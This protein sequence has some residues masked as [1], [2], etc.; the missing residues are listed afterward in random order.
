MTNIAVLNTFKRIEKKYILSQ[1]TYQELRN[2]LTDTMLED[3]YGWDTICSLYYDSENFDLIRRSIDKPSYK[4]KLR[5][6]SYNV[7]KNDTKVYVELKKKYNKVVYKRRIALKYDDA[8]K[9]LE[10]HT[11]PSD[12]ST[13]DKQIAAELLYALD[14]YSLRP[15]MII[16]YDRVALFCKD[17]PSLRITFDTNIRSRNTDL[18]LSNGCYG[19]PVLESGKYIM[20]IKV[21]GSMPLWLVKIL[22]E[23]NIDPGSFSKYGTASKQLLGLVPIPSK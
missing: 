20:E 3:Q 13:K 14:F 11:L 16:A 22:R 10:N 23:L 21:N 17:E 9:F 5:L 19:S 12:L 2:K 1:D 8:I 6:R 18:D 4:E 7:P 15:S